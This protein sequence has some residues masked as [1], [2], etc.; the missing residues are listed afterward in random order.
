M[1][2]EVKCQVENCK[3]NCHGSCEATCLKVNTCQ[4][5]KA[6]NNEETECATFELK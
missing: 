2:K 6:V 5:S 4:C 3:H 1:P